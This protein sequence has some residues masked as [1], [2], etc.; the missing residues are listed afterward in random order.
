[1]LVG[2]AAHWPEFDKTKTGA[3]QEFNVAPKQMVTTIKQIVTDPPL[4]I[5]V[6]EEAK[7]TI[8]TGYQSFP[9]DWHVA[10]RW[11][12]RTQYRVLVIPDFDDPT[13]KCVVEVRELTEQRAAEGMKWAPAAD[14]SRPERAEELLKTIRQRVNK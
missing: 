14:L 4:S 3:R 8:L 1:M 5:G 13:G 6:Q 10:R 2:C 9:G 11:Q 12:E 7:G